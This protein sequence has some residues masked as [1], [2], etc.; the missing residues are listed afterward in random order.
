[1]KRAPKLLLSSLTLLELT[2]ED[3]EVL[4]D[5]EQGLIST[6]VDAR[7][8]VDLATVLKSSNPTLNHDSAGP[9]PSCNPM[10]NPPD[11]S[12][13]MPGDEQ[14]PPL[15]S[16]SA[17]SLEIENGTCP[18]GEV[19]SDIKLKN[20]SQQ[21]EKN[22]NCPG[23]DCHMGREANPM[24]EYSEETASIHQHSGPM[25]SGEYNSN[26]T[27]NSSDAQI[28]PSDA[29]GNPTPSGDFKDSTHNWK[30]ESALM[31]NDHSTNPTSNSSTLSYSIYIDH[32]LC[33]YFVEVGGLRPKHS[34][35]DAQFYFLDT[36]D[37]PDWQGILRY[38][39]WEQHGLNS[40]G[41]E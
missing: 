40:L 34:T 36:S 30:A 4:L 6:V 3:L 15:L 7:R 23:Y 10:D 25:Q 5:D 35:T 8:P 41:D 39:H 32:D 17:S 37:L 33:L 20:N 18:E 12:A 31:P 24:S 29:K 2:V 22:G 11:K 19:H 13:R 26:T 27:E 38:L 14:T 21:T 16:E 1:V 9:H 28:V